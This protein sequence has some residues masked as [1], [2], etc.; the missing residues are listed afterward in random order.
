MPPRNTVYERVSTA[1]SF[2]ETIPWTASAMNVATGMATRVS[3]RRAVVW[4]VEER[5]ARATTFSAGSGIRTGSLACTEKVFTCC[6]EEGKA[7]KGLRTD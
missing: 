4:P 2:F 1:G 5:K 6:R 3:T 7:R